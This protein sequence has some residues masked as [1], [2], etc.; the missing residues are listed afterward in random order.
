MISESDLAFDRE[1]TKR[2]RIRDLLGLKKK[3][4]EKK[5]EE[6]EPEENSDV[7]WEEEY[8]QD[9]ERFLDPEEER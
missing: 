6:K 3:Q 4:E 7:A 8:S 5:K 9:D 1:T 2:L